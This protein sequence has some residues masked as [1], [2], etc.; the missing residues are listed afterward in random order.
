MYH[1]CTPMLIY[2]LLVRNIAVARSFGTYVSFPDRTLPWRVISVS[3]WTDIRGTCDSVRGSSRETCCDTPT[4]PHTCK[5]FRL[6][7]S[8]TQKAN[9]HA[10]FG[11]AHHECLSYRRPDPHGSMHWCLVVLRYWRIR[12]GDS[13]R[14][15]LIDSL[16]I[17]ADATPAD[18]TWAR[19]FGMIPCRR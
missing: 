16:P 9:R 7:D 13:V 10:A 1:I 3:Y 12:V 14:S 2:G 19:S 8:S 11:T 17:V 18:A 4:S 5:P 15:I 6:T